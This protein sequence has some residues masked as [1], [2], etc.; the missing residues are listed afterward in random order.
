[1]GIQDAELIPVTS[2]GAPALYCVNAPITKDFVPDIENLH[3]DKCLPK[4]ILPM[5]VGY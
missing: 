1:M 5:C 2:A 3:F 4:A